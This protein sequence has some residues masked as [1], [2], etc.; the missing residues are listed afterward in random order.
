MLRPDELELEND[1]RVCAKSL[2]AFV[3][4]GW[5]VLEPGQPYIHGRHVDAM[6]EHL[7][8]VTSGEIKRLLM[9]V[10]PGTMKSLLVGVFWP[11]WEWGPKKLPHHRFLGTSHAHHLAVRDNMKMRRLVQSE[12]FQSRWP[13]ALVGDQNAKTK[14]ENDKSG[15][16]EAMAFTGLTGSRGDRVLIDDPLSVSDAASEVKRESVNLEF[17]EA[18]PSRLNNPDRSAIVV[19]MQRLHER[20]VAGLILAGDYGYEHL[21]L[22]MEFEADRRCVTSIGFRDWRS[23][24]GELLFPERFP[25]EVVER[26]KRIMG[27]YAAAGQFQQRPAPRE[28]GMFKRAWFEGK[29]VAAAPVGTRWVRHWDLAA[30]RGSDAARTAGVKIGKSPDGRFFVGHVVTTRDEGFAVRKLIKATAESDGRE[31][32]ISLPQDPGQAGKAQAQDMIAMLAGFK[33][34]AAPETGD[35]ATRAEPFS[36][37]CEAGNVYLVKGE[38]HELYLDE[39]CL[40]PG[41]RF[42]DQVDASSGAF[43]RLVGPRAPTALFG[44]YA[45]SAA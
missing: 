32:E 20:D 31:V 36:A 19:I 42:K 24:G 9:N 26:D 13:V 16:R 22:P 44:V 39:L 15:F 18:L 14:F 28:G 12:W 17:R 37:Q 43:S 4:A 8:A 34:R 11:A 45:G 30:T 7:E 27:S 35:K 29:F 25:R 3:R 33:A 23:E 5:H 38:W 2:A 21:C 10:P 6:A 40:F 1:R 41:G